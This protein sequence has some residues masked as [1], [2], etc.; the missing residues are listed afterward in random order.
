[1]PSNPGAPF[2]GC[3]NS[4]FSNQTSSLLPP[5]FNFKICGAAELVTNNDPSGATTM[6][7]QIGATPGSSML[8][9]P[10]PDVRSKPFMKLPVTALGPRTPNEERSLEQTQTKLD[11]GSTETP[12]SERVPNA[13][14]SIHSSTIAGLGLI[15]HTPPAARLVTYKL[16]SGAE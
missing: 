15:R 2:E 6:S 8:T 10:S 14:G 12:R 9:L 4:A 13:P 16:P 7:L 5:D 1:M 3:L 11:W